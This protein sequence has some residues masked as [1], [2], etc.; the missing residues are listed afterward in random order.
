MNRGFASWVSCF[1]V[2]AAAGVA[3]ADTVWRTNGSKI[4]GKI[5]AEED[6]RIQVLFRSGT[7]EVKVWI[8]RSDIAYVELGKTPEEEFQDRLGRLDAADVEGHKSLIA[9]AKAN[10]LHSEAESLTARLPVIELAARKAKHPTRWC[11]TCD[12]V[13]ESVCAECKGSGKKLRPCERCEGKGKVLCQV[14]GHREGNGV[15]RCKRCSGAGEYERFDP[16]KGRKVKTKCSDCAGK[17]THKC[18]ECGG[19][20]SAPCDVCHGEKGLPEPC[21]VCGGTPRGPCTICKG[22]GL[23]PIALTPE[24]LEQE[25]AANEASARGKAGEGAPESKPKESEG[26]QKPESRPSEKPTSRPGSA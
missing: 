23:Q 25:K 6:D 10:L 22:T 24:E 19:K 3:S 15:L 20:Q 2:L 12:A 14:C 13:G 16:A 17:G 9:W 11:R 18:P 1:L 26:S 21:G 5:I 8:A 7:Q 4:V